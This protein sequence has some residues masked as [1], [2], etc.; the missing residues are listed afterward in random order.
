MTEEELLSKKDDKEKKKELLFE[1]RFQT[2]E[3]EIMSE[4]YNLR[5]YNHL[6]STNIYTRI[7]KETINDS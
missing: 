2:L 7:S 5:Y 6:G 1:P 3:D 4:T